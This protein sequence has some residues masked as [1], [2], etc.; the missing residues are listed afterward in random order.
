ME[1]ENTRYRILGTC[2]DVT[3]CDCCGRTN[4][5]RTVALLVNDFPKFFGST[6]AA[7]AMGY[8][9]KFVDHQAER[10]DW[11]KA[12]PGKAAAADRYRAEEAAL[13]ERCGRMF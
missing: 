13:A 9:K 5:K 3:T 12:N 10:M 8:G 1:T 7:R 2:D 6:C 4:L 11:R